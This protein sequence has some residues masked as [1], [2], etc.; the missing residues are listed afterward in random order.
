MTELHVRIPLAGGAVLDAS[1]GTPPLPLAVAVVAVA[2]DEGGDQRG[3]LDALHAVHVATLRVD[4]R[5]GE[6][7]FTAPD[8][9]AQ[10]LVQVSRWARQQHRGLRVAYVGIGD[11]GTAALVAAAEHPEVVD[12]VVTWNARSE[13]AGA[14]LD[15]PSVPSL[16]LDPEGD[17]ETEDAARRTVAWVR[18]RAVGHRQAGTERPV[19]SA[20]R[21]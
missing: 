11:A 2:A 10:R 9:L 16:L 12:A 5:D 7:A 8:L 21:G 13:Q 3:L 20:H 6:P 14:W 18:R 15:T 17:R 4:L 1:L 19:A